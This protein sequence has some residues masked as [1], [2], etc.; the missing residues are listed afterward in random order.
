MGWKRSHDV[1]ICYKET[2]ENGERTEDSVIAQDIYNALDK[3]GIRTFLSRV[4]LS[5]HV[6]ENYEPYI[7]AAL[8]SAKVMLMVTTKSEYCESIWVKNEW[9]RFVKLKE[10]DPSRS[11][12]PVYKGISPYELPAEL[13]FY[14]GQDIGKVGSLQDLIAGIKKLLGTTNGQIKNKEIETL[15]TKERKKTKKKENR[16]KVLLTIGKVLAVLLIATGVFFGASRL[17]YKEKM[18]TMPADGSIPDPSEHNM[19]QVTINTAD[20]DNYFSLVSTN[21]F[22]ALQSKLYEQGWYIYEMEEGKRIWFYTSGSTEISDFKLP[23]LIQTRTSNIKSVA[24]HSTTVTYVHKDFVRSYQM[25]EDGKRLLLLKNGKV[26]VDDFWE[27][28][29]KSNTYYAKYQM[30]QYPY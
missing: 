17:I 18:T 9:G 22:S 20:F 1:F 3:E 15:L 10:E 21:G 26:I 6:G 13:Q 8:S 7:F 11:I 12:I 5:S 4:S 23:L 16:R 14:Q 19:F 2:D 30:N 29:I 24:F 28:L 25:K 27:W